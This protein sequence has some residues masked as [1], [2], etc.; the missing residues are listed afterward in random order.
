MKSEEIKQA[1]KERYDKVA[2]TSSSCC[3][4]SCGCSSP[5]E[6][7]IT[8]D[9]N[10]SYKTM[11]AAISE[12]ADL[13]LGCGIPVEFADF[14]Q[15]MTVL[16]LGSG[17]GIDVFFAAKAVGPTGHAIG[18]DMTESMIERASANREK[19]GL[20]NTEFRLGE[21]ENMPVESNSIDRVLSNCVINLVPDKLK[22][23]QEIYRVLKPGGSF[24][25]SDTVS[26]GNIPQ[27]VRENT[28]LWGA[29]VAGSLEKSDYLETIRKAGF[30]SVEILKA[31]RYP[32]PAIVTFGIESITVRGT[33]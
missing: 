21:I 29:C 6:Q 23:F 32:V 19:L 33:K 26:I 5:D 22:S 25:I 7:G 1:V 2:K 28:E 30:K 9:L 24:V 31:K 3:G 12:V 16:D 4:P 15:G 17:A 27:S 10:S 13:G 8:F 14:H 18:L 20:L 11:D